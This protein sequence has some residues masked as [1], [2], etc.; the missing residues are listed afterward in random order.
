[1]KR[2]LFNLQNLQREELIK[3]LIEKCPELVN[4]EN[5]SDNKKTIS[6]KATGRT[7]DTSAYE[8]KMVALK[9]AYFGFKY[10]G[11][12]SQ[13]GLL[14]LF[15][16][17]KIVSNTADTVEDHIFR[18][19]IRTRLILDPRTCNYSRCG[20]TDAGV[21]STG[22]V[23]ALRL[24]TSNQKSGS[25]ANLLGI[26]YVNVINKQ[27]PDDIRILDWSFVPDDFSARFSCSSRL[28]H[29]YF[30]KV[31][32]D[33]ISRTLVNLDI[34]NMK[35]AAKLLVG[36]HDFRNFC[37]RDPSKPE[38]SFVR[39]I[40]DTYIEEA[41]GVDGFYKFVCKGSAFLYHQIRCIMSILFMIGIGSEPVELVKVMLEKIESK[42][43]NEPAGPLVHY[44][45]ASGIPL[46]L[47]ECS[48]EKPG[49]TPI[50]WKHKVNSQSVS[51]H[52][53]RLWESKQGEAMI[54][55]GLLNS[56]FAL[57]PPKYS[58]LFKK[59]NEVASK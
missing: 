46:T 38:Q 34:D 54:I 16:E 31:H 55:K 43:S 1:M 57:S 11:F 20:R 47:Y 32:F 15:N 25:S 50:E 56:E 58:N 29:Y 5:V 53:Y 35:L 45:I 52:L 40:I 13:T 10:Q 23:I 14:N 30:S 3:L 37:K 51:S 18:A 42:K 36:V 24:R 44:E 26:D 17:I 6:S 12:A 48:Y 8:S 19:L 4:E 7:F 2:P 22:Q 49:S 28:Y 59:F 9:V 41:D 39:E 21:S 33:H 27:L